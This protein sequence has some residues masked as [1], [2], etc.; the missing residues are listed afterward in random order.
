MTH[1]SVCLIFTF[2][3]NFLANLQIP[4]NIYFFVALLTIKRKPFVRRQQLKFLKRNAR[5]CLALGTNY[6]ESP[7][8]KPTPRKIILKCLWTFGNYAAYLLTV[9][10]QPYSP[11]SS[12]PTIAR[13]RNSFWIHHSGSDQRS[14]RNSFDFSDRFAHL[15]FDFLCIPILVY[16]IIL[17]FRQ[18]DMQS[19]FC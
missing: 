3:I 18:T 6:I 9:P 8:R 14:M 7:S 1:K 5:L 4:T 17:R 11:L 12:C 16:K 2:G 15:C 10:E 13:E 19:K